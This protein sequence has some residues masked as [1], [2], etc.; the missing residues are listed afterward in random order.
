MP[1]SVKTSPVSP[2]CQLRV[3]S[4]GVGREQV[5]RRAGER[6][7][8][9]DMI[10]KMKFYTGTRINYPEFPVSC[11]RLTVMAMVG[12]ADRTANR[13]EKINTP[14]SKSISEQMTYNAKN[15]AI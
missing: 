15:I 1:R 5:R 9:L 10:V 11:M 7:F 2:P 14:V 4:L 13:V 6:S 3:L 12:M 8:S